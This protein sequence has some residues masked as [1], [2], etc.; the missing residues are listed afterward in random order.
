METT[1]TASQISRQMLLGG[2]GTNKRREQREL[3]AAREVDLPPDAPTAMVAVDLLWLD[4]QPLVDVPLLER[5]RLLDAVLVDHE[6]VR[7][8]VLVRPPVQAW[9]AQWRGPR[10]PRNR[11]KAA[12][13]PYHPG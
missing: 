11:G 13:H 3:A 5:K 4:G 2:G 1:P 6:L 12:T 10:L 9:Y 7:R 8:T